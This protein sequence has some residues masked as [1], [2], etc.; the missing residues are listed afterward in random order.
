MACLG[1]RRYHAPR[2]EF[3]SSETGAGRR[4]IE[5]EANKS[6]PFGPTSPAATPSVPKSIQTLASAPVQVTAFL[7]E[8]L[9][10]AVAVDGRK[11]AQWIADLDSTTS[12]LR[13]VATSD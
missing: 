13:N 7:R 12:R 6:K 11:L 2:V 10:P 8:H 5:L 3:G 9:K 4:Q 1:Q